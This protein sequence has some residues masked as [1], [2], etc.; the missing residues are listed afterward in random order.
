MALNDENTA[1][2]NL[3]R[4]QQHLELRYESGVDAAAIIAAALIDVAQSQRE[5]VTELRATRQMLAELLDE[6]IN[7]E[8]EP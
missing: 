4:I 6:L 7:L 5:L 2:L 3:G 1:R 8:T